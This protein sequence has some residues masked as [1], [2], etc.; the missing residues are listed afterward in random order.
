MTDL[1][2]IPDRAAQTAGVLIAFLGVAIVGLLTTWR[3]RR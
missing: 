2:L 1:W 3:A